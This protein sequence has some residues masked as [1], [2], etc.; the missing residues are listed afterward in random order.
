MTYRL[1][2]DILYAYGQTIEIDSGYKIAPAYDI[3]WMQPDEN[4]S[5]EKNFGKLRVSVTTSL[6]QT[7]TFL[8]S[9]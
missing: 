4:F 9:S 1:D 5:G 7:R 8:K 6:F 2:S 3:K